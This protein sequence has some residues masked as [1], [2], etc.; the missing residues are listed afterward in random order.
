[1]TERFDAVV[2]GTG[3]GGGPLAGALAAAGRRTAIV[4]R[5]E[6]GGTCINVG[7]TP[8]K[9]MVASARIAYLARRAADYGVETGSIAIDMSRVR[10]RKRAIVHDFRAGSTASLE[11]QDGLTLFR[12]DARFIAP[13]TLAVRM[14]NNEEQTLSTDLIVLNPG[15]RSAV[16]SL[17]GLETVDALDSTSIMELDHVPDHLLV[18]GGG[19][20]GLEFGQMFRR[21]GAN[22][23]IVQRGKRLLAREDTDIAD[24]IAAI[25]REDGITI[26]LESDA[27]AV[28]LAGDAA[29]DLTIRMGT[30]ERHLS[31]S[32]LLVATGRAPNTDALNLAAGG[33]RTDGHG[34]VI[35]DEHLATSAP[36]VY[37]IGDAKGGPAFTHIAYDD[38]RIL[39]ANLIE[40]G[41]ASI[42]NRQVPYTVFIDPQL[43]RIGLG[44]DEAKAQG[45]AIR[46][47]RM[48]M[49]SVARAIET[50]ET[51]GF[52]K[53]VVDAESDRILGAAILGIE[54]GELM[55]MLQIAMLGNLP[56]TALRDATFAHPTLAESFNNLFGQLGNT[57]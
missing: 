39:R 31:G 27:I 44:E 43:G 38:F 30:D 29:I 34:Y 15:L 4:E 47:A 49:A 48:P 21:F 33:I 7:C 19:Y 32:H 14:A 25:L 11:K 8:T 20:I 54:G 6:I 5:A 56:Y 26:H 42:R 17:P 28:A 10:E 40:G 52:M 3:Q 18:L 2:V 23:T 16:S 1:M 12:G 45:R 24:A 9:T 51:R 57:S 55:S 50:D 35:A 13:K 37:V 53:V 41:R 46:V 22:V 36:D